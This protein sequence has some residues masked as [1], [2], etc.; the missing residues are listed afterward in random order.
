[1]S[2]VLWI[3]QILLALAFLMA[4]VMKIT[5]PIESLGKRMTWTAAIPPALVRFI[6]L[7]EMLGGIGLIL[8]MIT[9]ILPG[10][11]VVAA[12]SLAIVMVLAAVFHLTRHEAS[13][14]PMNMILLA[15]ALVVIVGRLAV[16]PV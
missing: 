8:P 13:H 15:L 7:A 6:G 5:Q 1:M 4:G 9:G 16:V 11:T 12:V 3:A 10:L 14:V 2:V